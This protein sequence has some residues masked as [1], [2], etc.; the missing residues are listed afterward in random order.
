MATL[1]NRPVQGVAL[2]HA[3]QAVPKVSPVL[4]AFSG[5]M[6]LA[7]PITRRTGQTFVKHNC[8]V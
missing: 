7:W 8:H 5:N 2:R 6:R 4:R 1:L 3:R